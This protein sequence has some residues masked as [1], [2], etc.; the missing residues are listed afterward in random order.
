[1]GDDIESII[2]NNRYRILNKIGEGRFGQVFKG[3][4]EK[5]RRK[6]EYVAIKF[7][8]EDENDLNVLAHEAKMLH[9]LNHSSNNYELVYGPQLYWY[10]IITPENEDEDNYDHDGDKDQL[11]LQK[12]TTLV[13]SY[14]DI[15]LIQYIQKVPQKFKTKWI[16]D[17]LMPQMINAIH[18]I[19][20]LFV[21][22]R[23]I[24]PSNFMMH[25]DSLR[26]IDFGMSTFYVDGEGEH[27]PKPKM[28]INPKK[29]LIG[30]PNYASVFVHQGWPCTRRDDLISSAYVILYF[31]I[32]GKNGNIGSLPWEGLP[33]SPYIIHPM[34]QERMN[35][36]IEV[37][38]IAPPKLAAFLRK[39]YALD[40]N[41]DLDIFTN[42]KS[43]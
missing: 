34:N 22:H 18:N 37:I 33:V 35:K 5:G 10:G 4:V 13:M 19:H 23:D 36:K 7:E 15:P 11:E 28:E 8:L 42:N 17:T 41:E 30:S 9:Y 43:I 20:E 6:G 16:L 40:F 14:Y 32:G 29:E 1:M 31:L 26:I 12:M 24:K 27:F 21:I 2:I 25:G 38:K 3:I 39:C